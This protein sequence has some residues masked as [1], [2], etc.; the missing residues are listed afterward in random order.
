TPFYDK[1][2]SERY[3][4]WLRER[5]KPGDLAKFRAGAGVQGEEPAPRLASRDIAT[6]PP[7]RFY[8]EVE[9][10][11]EMERRYFREM[12]S[13]LKNTLKVRQP[14]VGTADHSHSTSGYALLSSTS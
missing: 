7:E 10:F 14:V 8:T 4:G 5:F 13:Y 3:N 2:L 9:F 6:S 11:I 1:E 12:E